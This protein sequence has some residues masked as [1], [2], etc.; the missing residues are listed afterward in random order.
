MAGVD[1]ERSTGG[2]LNTEE[3]V[4]TVISIAQRPTIE[5]QEALL[6]ERRAAGPPATA[7]YEISTCRKAPMS[8]HVIVQLPSP[9][10]SRE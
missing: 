1:D 8:C 2:H 9:N 3:V 4:V 7:L 10:V 5:D 6:A